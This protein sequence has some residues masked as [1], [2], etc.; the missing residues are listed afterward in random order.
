METTELSTT[1]LA[2]L[3]ELRIQEKALKAQID[4]VKPLAIEEAKKLAPE[5]GG[6]FTVDGV[7][8]FVLDVVPVYDLSDYRRYKEDEAKEWRSDKREQRIA[9]TMASSYTASMRT[10]MNNFI[11]L[12]RATKEPDSIDYNLKC[13]GL[14]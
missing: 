9:R 14:D 5:D 8:E 1:N 13:V 6:K 10:L 12:Y 7:G 2:A 4:I 11:K 3:R